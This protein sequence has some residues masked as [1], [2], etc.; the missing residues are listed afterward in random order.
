MR[1]KRGV[2]LMGS[3]GEEW[4]VAVRIGSGE[5][6]W[7]CFKNGEVGERGYCCVKSEWGTRRG[8]HDLGEGEGGGTLLQE[9]G[10][11]GEERGE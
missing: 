1:E 4:G 11:G 3:G 8:I 10:R 7:D 5:P 6:G 2:V 9:K